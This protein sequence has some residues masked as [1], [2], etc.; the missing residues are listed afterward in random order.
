MCN[1]TAI[2]RSSG[3]NA[4]AAAAYRSATKLFNERDGL[5]YDFSRKKGVEF[6]EILLPEGVEAQW[7]LDRALLWNAAERYE[8][9]RNSR[10]AIEV[11]VAL[12]HELMREEWV[13]LAHDFSQYLA[14]RYLVAVDMAVHRPA[15]ETDHR[16]LHAHLLM[17]T[18]TVGPDGLG[19]KIAL[20][21]RN[22]WLK[23]NGWPDTREELRLLR[24]T[25]AY[26]TNRYLARA[27]LEVRID[28]RSY[29]QLGIEIEPTQHMGRS[30]TQ[31]T[32][33]GLSPS[34]VRI[35]RKS[36][37][38][39]ADLIRKQPEQILRLV[40]QEKSVFDRY[41]VARALHRY[42]DDA[43]AFKDTFAAAMASPALVTLC[44]ERNGETA[45]YSTR[46]M[47][48][49]EQTMIA[50]AARMAEAAK[51]RVERRH[52]EQALIAQDDIIKRVSD[53]P[54]KEG[55]SADLASAGQ[56]DGL[57][58]A[59]GRERARPGLSKEQ[60]AAVDHI[61]GPEQIAA[62]VGFAGA[63]KSTMLAAAR[64]AWQRQGYRVH[65]AALAGM[66][67]EGLQLASGIASRT[68]ASWE[69]AWQDGKRLLG[70]G[71][72]LVVDEAGMLSSRQLARLITKAEARGAK[73]VLVGDHEQLQ[74]IGAG[75]P[76][77]AVVER[78]GAVELSEIRRQTQTWQREASIALA[79]RRTGEGLAAYADRG[80][81]R[82]SS[83]ADEARANLVRD[84]LADCEAHPTASRLALAHRRVDVHALNNAIRRSLQERGW[85]G[86]K[87]PENGNGD[88]KED[89]HGERLD[90]NNAE[91]LYQTNN[92]KRP[93]TPGDRI[94]F[95]QNDRD[96]GVKNGMLGT[97]QA[98][99]PDALT[100]KLDQSGRKGARPVSIPV[101]A[102]QAFD[103]GYATTIHKSQGA[104]VDRSLVLGSPTM[105]RHLTYV[106]M[107]RHRMDGKLYVGQDD[108][109][110]MKAL[111]A[112]MSRS[113]AK[114]TTLDYVSTF[115]ERRGLAERLDRDDLVRHH[116]LCARGEGAGETAM[117][118]SISTHMRSP[119][120]HA[121]VSSAEA[122]G[123]QSG[124]GAAEKVEP[125]LPALK[126]YDRSV[127]EVGR[128]RASKD[129]QRE[130]E[131][132]LS[133]GRRVYADPATVVRS[134]AAA[135][136]NTNDGQKLA[137]AVARRPEQFG[138]LRGKAGL[139]GENEERKAARHDAVALSRLLASAAKTWTRRLDEERRS[140]A[141]KREKCDVVVV[142]GLTKQSEAI[143]REFDQIPQAEKPKFLE[144]L[145]AG[146]DGK[147]ALKEAE[148][149]TRALETR[150]GKTNLNKVDT[151]ELGLGRLSA[152]QLARI[153]DVARVA[154]RA[155][156]AELSRQYTAKRSRKRSL[157]LSLGM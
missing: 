58:P 109:K 77:R 10:V 61:T 49:I 153:T 95:L 142:P 11:L 156:A 98:V 7:A 111:A 56:S 67:A 14:N 146:A 144:K 46:E 65:G 83:T 103:H 44:P 32:R 97:V 125:L 70:K 55:E 131:A 60:R 35:E 76:F 136:L 62:V 115:A 134:F 114:E 94:V 126:K 12:P 9:R 52:F 102:Y 140:E 85:L 51:Y 30:A 41:D 139:L 21:R 93:F 152:A 19:E 143:L 74:A 23:D 75:S 87:A 22:R 25:W 101:G 145:Q 57:P 110:D 6:T 127:E 73:L 81:V 112:S 118:T 15:Q 64:D 5:T 148:A 79:T 107:S 92:G 69:Y 124:A 151:E 53:A 4:V 29:A 135:I 155:H 108:F 141:W 24:Q 72:V 26:H 96:L 84:Y 150:F 68:L 128:E 120:D 133:F 37:E 154:E 42:I 63:G 36:A 40:T 117:G 47:I 45:R 113:G 137:E 48:G 13:S 149:I 119:A 80:G 2:G 82:F 99:E 31:M 18:R 27:G 100:V 3:G 17:T 116:H 129:L 1:I 89:S 78:V 132:V 106:A 39:N 104:T 121:I 50:G 59:N 66:A 86:A 157:G 91:I 90:P 105:D 38:R 122:R 71:D 20:G 54:A 28:H 43:E 147:Q 8:K 34:R 16:N 138:E 33:Q 88:G 130:L 123:G